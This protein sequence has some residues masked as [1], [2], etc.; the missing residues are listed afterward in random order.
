MLSSLCVFL[1]L[2][3]P[4][5]LGDETDSPQAASPRVTE[6]A[7]T[8]LADAMDALRQALPETSLQC[9]PNTAAKVREAAVAVMEAAVAVNRFDNGVAP[10]QL[11]R[12]A[13]IL[14]RANRQVEELV[15]STMELRT[16]FADL[17]EGPP[18]RDAAREFLAV[19]NLMTDL[20]GRFRYTLFDPDTLDYIEWELV[21][22]PEQY[23]QLLDL[24][25]ESRCTVG[26]TIAAGSLLYPLE[27]TAGSDEV[28]IGAATKSRILQ[29][30]AATGARDVLQ[31]L[32]EFLYSDTATPAL[33][34]ET[35]ETIRRLGVPQSPRPNQ[36]PTLPQ[37]AVTP[38]K[39]RAILLEMHTASLNAAEFHRRSSLLKWLDSRVKTGLEEA[40]YHLGRYDVRPGDWLLMRNPSPYNLF[41][42]LSPGLYT[43]VGVV[44]LE[45]G[46]D[47]VRRMVVVDLPERGTHMPATNVDLFVQRTLDYVFLRANDRTVAET[48]GEVAAS[49]IGNPVQFD[50]NFR[51]DNIVRLRGRPLKGEKITGY[52]AGLLLLCAQETDEPRA[53]FFPIPE[54]PA[55]GRLL[56]N[57]G[58]LGLSVGDDF[59]SPTGAMFSPMLEMVGRSEAMYDPRREVEQAIYDY[60]AS[61]LE[62]RT[63]TPSDDLYQ[64]L[65]LKVAQMSSANS[66]LSKALARVAGVGSETDL[67]TAARAAAVVETLDQ[68]AYGSSGEFLEARQA[69]QFNGEDAS[70]DAAP[71][72]T[73][74]IERMRV[75]RRRHAELL[76]RWNAGE[77]SPRR[78]RIELVEYYINQGQQRIDERFFS[79]D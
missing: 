27:K 5:N 70:P 12:Y 77:L 23:N 59:V 56:E 51:T 42:D 22:F 79:K 1:A 30:I 48:M 41:T 62:T 24:F 37:P 13:S 65:R 3:I 54:Y 10:E 39:L 40:V 11:L 67:V 8:Q 4:V 57:I 68:V 46:T 71:R 61:S 44:A 73:D 6:L 17:P 26:A 66:L 34:I 2:L 75:L 45:Q 15:E 38:E 21:E 16:G 52:C 58:T 29:V 72:N 31:P 36:D 33:M 32:T 55:G 7:V 9:V 47:G 28:A 20:A 76:R 64:S 63:L 19:A 78:L 69:I 25:T 60:F 53:S 49:I 50:L 35:I 74:S 43:H 18:R 14:V